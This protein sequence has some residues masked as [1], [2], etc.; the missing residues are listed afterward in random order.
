MNPL[1]AVVPSLLLVSLTSAA[2]AQSQSES[3]PQVTETPAP[4]SEAS[5]PLSAA[6]PDERFRFT[7]APYI[8]LTSVSGDV[9]IKGVQVDASK[10]FIEI[11]EDSDKVFG[12]MG[13]LELEY[14][15]FVFQLNGAWTTAEIKETV[16]L[17]SG[18]SID[19]DLDLS[20]A[21]FELFAGYRV[22]DRELG[23]AGSAQRL[24]ADVFLGGRITDVNSDASLTAAT[25]IT[26]PD[27]VTMIPAGAT[28]E[29]DQTKTWFEPFIGARASVLLSEHW[30]LSLRGDVGGFG[31]SGADFAWQVV[32]GVGYSWRMKSATAEAFLGYRALGQD[33]TDGDF[34][35]DVVTH[36]PILGAQLV[37]EF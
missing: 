36:G 1:N 3:P 13:A 35:W 34:A 29:I 5:L 22:L 15:D 28:A 33:Y 7:F 4:A 16:S 14:R 32:G 18:S 10:T 8:W 26:L 24:H 21:W 12:L 11:L 9:T 2:G 6:E 30:G 19:T 23:S 31:V 37:W 17:A 25:D 27:G 20:T